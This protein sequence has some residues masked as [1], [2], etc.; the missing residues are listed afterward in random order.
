MQMRVDRE[1]HESFQTQS[2]DQL[3]IYKSIG[4]NEIARGLDPPL[5]IEEN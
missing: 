4:S 1:G 5:T 3:S 2:T